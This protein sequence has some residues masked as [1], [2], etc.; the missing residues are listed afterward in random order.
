MWITIMRVVLR[1][2]PVGRVFAGAFAEV[3]I[4]LWVLSGIVQKFFRKQSS[5]FQ[6]EADR[7]DLNKET[8]ETGPKTYYFNPI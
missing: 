7:M 1:A 4:W 2:G 5:I 3:A 8:H 6:G